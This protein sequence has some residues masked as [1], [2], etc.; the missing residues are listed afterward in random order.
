[1]VVGLDEGIFEVLGKLLRH[2]WHSQPREL[3]AQMVDSSV[4]DVAAIAA[5]GKQA[6]RL[7]VQRLCARPGFEPSE[8]VRLLKQLLWIGGDLCGSSVI[9]KNCEQNKTRAAKC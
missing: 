6:F 5:R 9:Q 2:L 3:S 8:T 7:G 4:Q 1:M